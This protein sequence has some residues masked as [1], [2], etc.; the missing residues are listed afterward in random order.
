MN[1]TKICGKCKQELPLTSEFYH[2]MKSNSDGF[3]GS[4]KACRKQRAKHVAEHGVEEKVLDGTKQCCMCKEKFPATSEHFHKHKR[5]KDYGLH[6]TCKPCTKIYQKQYRTDNKEKVSKWNKDY[7]ARSVVKRDRSEYNKKYNR[8]NRKRINDLTRIRR[9]SNPEMHKERRRLYEKHRFDTDHTFRLTRNLRRRLSSAINGQ[10]KS[11][12]TMELIG[13]S[14]DE[15]ISYLE[16]LFED[17]MDW[18][19]YGKWL[20]GGP[21]TW[22]VDHIKPCAS[23]DM[24]KPEQQRECFNYKNL[25]PLCS[26]ENIVKGDK[27]DYPQKKG[28]DF[29]PDP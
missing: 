15:L 5:D 23:F 25:Q 19:C 9:N 8:D 20:V 7:L 3:R 12:S 4:C 28:Q 22:V 27:L 10:N 17:W 13:C 11:A 24:S 26:R 21:R 16:G 18:D 29:T 2:R 1:D 6:N 14:I